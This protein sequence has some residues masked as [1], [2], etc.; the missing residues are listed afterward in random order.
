MRGLH[1]SHISSAALQSVSSCCNSLLHAVQASR[2][3]ALVAGAS[4][5]WESMPPSVVTEPLGSSVSKAAVQQHNGLVAVNA[6]LLQ[7]TSEQKPSTAKFLGELCQHIVDGQLGGFGQFVT[8]SLFVLLRRAQIRA[9]LGITVATCFAAVSASSRSAVGCEPASMEHGC[10]LQVYS[11]IRTEPWLCEMLQ[12][13]A[14]TRW[15]SCWPR[16]FTRW[17]L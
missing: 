5:S 7:S 9:G 6:H 16:R 2:G 11:L 8:S 10:M 15:L 13:C 14:S 12:S 4:D 3:W 1:L 17:S